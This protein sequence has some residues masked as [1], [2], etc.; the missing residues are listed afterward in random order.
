LQVVGSSFAPS[1]FE[2]VLIPITCFLRTFSSA[3]ISIVLPYD[4]LIFWPSVPGTTATS[5]S[6]IGS[7]SLNV[8]PNRLLKFWAMSRA[9]SMCCFWSWPTG[10]MSGW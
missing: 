3:K 4:L 5:F 7:G 9:I 2:S 8:S 10:T 6:I 1:G